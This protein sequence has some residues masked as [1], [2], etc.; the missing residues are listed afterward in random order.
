[1]GLQSLA[2]LFNFVVCNPCQS[3][4]SLTILVP[5]W[6]IIIS[7]ADFQ[8]YFQVSFSLKVNLSMVKMRGVVSAVWLPF[9]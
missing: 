8:L 7:F 4:P 1:M 5:W 2:K 9:Y 3:S 6:L